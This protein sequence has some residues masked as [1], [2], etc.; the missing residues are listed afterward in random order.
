[1]LQAYLALAAPPVA[2]LATAGHPRCRAGGAESGPCE[3]W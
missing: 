1:M 3:V 2:V